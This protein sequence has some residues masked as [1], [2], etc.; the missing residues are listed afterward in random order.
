[1]HNPIDRIAHTTAFLTPVVEHWLERE[2]AQWVH[3]MKDRYDDPSHRER[4]LLP[5]SYI[6]L[7]LLSKPPPPPSHSHHGPLL[8]TPFDFCMCTKSVMGK[9]IIAM[10]SSW[11]PR[12]RSAPPPLL[13]PPHPPQK[14]KLKKDSYATATRRLNVQ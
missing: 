3:P 8:A 4:T 10:Q 13:P 2:I 5:R 11:Q 6:S 14:K 9:K 1:M 12:R 7:L